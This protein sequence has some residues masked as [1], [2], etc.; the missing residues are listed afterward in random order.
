VTNSGTIPVL[1]HS[2]RHLASLWDKTLKKST[3]ITSD[4]VTTY[5]LNI[6]GVFSCNQ[7]DTVLEN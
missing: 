7:G 5:C 3:K 1:L 2:R 6:V 4:V